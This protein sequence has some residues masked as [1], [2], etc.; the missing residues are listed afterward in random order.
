MLALILQDNLN[1]GTL[2]I[3][4]KIICGCKAQQQVPVTSA[5][6]CL[7][8]SGFEAN[9]GYRMISEKKKSF[10][11]NPANNVYIYI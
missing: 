2:K 5:L 7:E 10:Q 3:F 1:A 4:C 11:K 6:R 8:D 9:L